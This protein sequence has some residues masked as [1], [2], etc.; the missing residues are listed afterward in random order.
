MVKGLF[1][2]KKNVL[3]EGMSE[4][5][6]LNSLSIICHVK[7]RQGLADDTYITPCG[8]T[9][10]VGNLASLFLGQQVRPLILLDADDAGRVRRDALMKELYVGYEKSILML[11]EVLGREACEIE[12]LIGEEHLLPLVNKVVG[13]A[14]AITQEDRVASTIPGQ[15][16]AA[17]RRL[18]IEL[19]EGWKAEVARQFAIG[20][21]KNYADDSMLV[22]RA[23]TLFRIMTERLALI[24]QDKRT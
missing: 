2:H 14:I 12:D 6:Y 1:R 22:E 15:V 9:K 5:F 11:S 7:N 18:N 21:D 23:E 19:P 3:V 4:Y 8:G 17:A 16:K 20:D 13:K 24:S 10:L